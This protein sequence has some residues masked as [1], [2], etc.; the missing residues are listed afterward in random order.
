MIGWT[1]AAFAAK[2]NRNNSCIWIAGVVTDN[3]GL[4]KI[5]R[6]NSCIWIPPKE[7]TFAEIDLD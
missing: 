6:N 2:I 1:P 5:N 7:N 4:S 3:A